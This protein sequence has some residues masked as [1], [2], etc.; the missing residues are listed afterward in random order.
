MTQTS[1]TTTD[2]TRNHTTLNDATPNHAPA[3][4]HTSANTPLKEKIDA[5]ITPLTCPAVTPS[6][7]APLQEKS[8]MITPGAEVIL[9]ENGT[10]LFH[11]AYGVSSLEKSP[12]DQVPLKRG[13]IFDLGTA[14]QVLVTAPILMKL[15]EQKLID[16]QVKVSRVLQTFGSAGKESMK[17]IHLL[18]HTSGY[19]SHLPLHRTLIKGAPTLNSLITRRS[20][21][22]LLYKE[23]YR[24]RLD[25]VPG[26]VHQQSDIG[27]LL[28]GQI[29]EVVSGSP[30]NKLFSQFMA[31]PFKLESTGFIDLEQIRRKTISVSEELIIPTTQCSWRKKRLHGEVLDEVAWA[32]GGI[33]SHNGLFGSSQDLITY[34]SILNDSIRAS[35]K[36]GR[37]KFFSSPISQMFTGC[38]LLNPDTSKDSE[39]SYPF[40]WEHYKLSDTKTVIGFWSSSGVGL[41]LDPYSGRSLV[42]L[43]NA[44]QI[45]RDLRKTKELALQVLAECIP[46]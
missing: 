11:K 36:C 1:S 32:L 46:H 25:N 23:I 37:G 34:L 22:H 24:S 44:V 43:S 41:W 10:V 35:E 39:L 15:V 5:L 6:G 4:G 18:N 9:A 8:K 19:T 27:Y 45:S 20:A 26:K 28:L 38:H 33:A 42:F 12:S 16:P 17:I 2:H 3:N 7:D 13:M 30:L 21:L 29:I 31:R 14:T 40:G